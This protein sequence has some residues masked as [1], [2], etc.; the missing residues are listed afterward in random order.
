MNTGGYALLNVYLPVSD[1]EMPLR[2]WRGQEPQGVRCISM[3]GLDDRHPG[4]KWQEALV[5][6]AALPARFEALPAWA[7]LITTEGSVSASDADHKS[8]FDP[9]GDRNPG[10]LHPVLEECIPRNALRL[11]R[12][13]RVVAPASTRAGALER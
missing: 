13:Q 1:S 4:H 3:N 10:D 9:F 7:L 5:Q 8:S 12:L 2:Y 11:W 6:A